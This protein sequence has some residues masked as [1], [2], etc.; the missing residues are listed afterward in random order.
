MKQFEP[1]LQENASVNLKKTLD[2]C[3]G[4]ESADTLSVRDVF[5]L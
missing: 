3:F 4:L 1:L 5:Y 2:V